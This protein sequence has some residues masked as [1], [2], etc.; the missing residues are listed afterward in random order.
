MSV[1]IASLTFS[2]GS[3]VIY[4]PIGCSHP[5]MIYSQP[6]SA[7]TTSTWSLPHTENERQRSVNG[8]SGCLSRNQGIALIFAFLKQLLTALIGKNTMYL[9]CNT[10]SK[11]IVIASCKPCKNLS[12][13]VENAILMRYCYH[14]PK[15]RALIE[16]LVGHARRP[17]DNPPNPDWLGVYHWT[18]P[19]LTVPVD[20][21]PR[22]SI[23]GSFGLDPEPDWKWW[24]RTVS[25][26]H[27]VSTI[28]GIESWVVYML[29]CECN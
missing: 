1:N 5:F 2:F 4:V 8:F 10:D 16:S 12:S 14:T 3:W 28:F 29:I 11:L 17:T 19:E 7:K 6:V 20:G 18:I 27:R 13:V 23:W 9:R 26:T 25:K 22:P 21:Q 24:A 15:T